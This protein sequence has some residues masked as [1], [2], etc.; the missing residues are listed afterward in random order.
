MKSADVPAANG[1]AAES[2]QRGAEEKAEGM[3][4]D[5]LDKPA[6]SNDSAPASASAAAKE[7]KEKEPK[8]A[9]VQIP[10]QAD[11]DDAV[12]Y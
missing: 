9:A 7:E 11:D 6:A 3:D 1:H 10:I 12:E 8:P 2:A 4:V 5:E